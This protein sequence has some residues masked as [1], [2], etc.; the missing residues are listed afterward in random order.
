MG[1]VL[2]LSYRETGGDDG[3]GP[4]LRLPFSPGASLSVVS[5]ERVSASV[6]LSKK[7][8]TRRRERTAEACQAERDRGG[9]EKE[10]AMQGDFTTR[11]RLSSSVSAFFWFVCIAQ[12]LGERL[13]ST[14]NL[15]LT[16]K[17]QRKAKKR[18]DL[19][20]KTTRRRRRRRICPP[21]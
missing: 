12:H 19:E 16:G 15:S 1:K 9:R 6:D 4:W 10:V 14:V 3:H 7:N 2:E 13:P 17:P 20:E 11:K 5:Q 18:L 8:K 21:C